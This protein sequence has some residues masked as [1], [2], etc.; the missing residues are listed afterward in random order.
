MIEPDLAA[1][2]ATRPT[3]GR[4]EQPTGTKQSPA[5]LLRGHAL[6]V[7]P[8]RGREEGALPESELRGARLELV[9]LVVEGTRPIGERPAG[10]YEGLREIGL[11]RRAG[12][13]RLVELVW[14][15]RLTAYF[16]SLHE[17]SEGATRL[18]AARIVLALAVLAGLVRVGRVD[19][20]DLEPP[21][22]HF[23]V[24]G[25]DHGGRA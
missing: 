7:A 17:P 19:T 9:L 10:R 25:I 4:L 2:R 14:P 15:A 1:A 6:T 12:G 5:A 22:G 3:H 16:L 8:L 11:A 20:V 18:D 24:A 13:Q 23:Q 21:A